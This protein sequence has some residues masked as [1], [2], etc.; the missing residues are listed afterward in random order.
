MAKYRLTQLQFD[1]I[2]QVRAAKHLRASAA[3]A[4]AAAK[5]VAKHIAQDVVEGIGPALTGTA[6]VGRFEA[7]VAVLIIDRALACIAEHLGGLLGFLEFV[8]GLVIAGIAIRM[9]LHRQAAIGLFDI[10]FGGRLRDIQ[11][12]VVIALRHSRPAEPL[13]TSKPPCPDPPLLAVEA[14]ARRHWFPPAYEARRSLSLTSSN[15]ASTTS[16]LGPAVPP[17]AAPAPAAPPAC[18][19]APP[20]P[21]CSWA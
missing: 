10:C 21:P 3:A 9:E 17:P 6:L 4:S 16:S 20:A 5:D 15:S 14:R 1:L 8:L 12:F 11:N 19:P 13:N 7:R 2:A 18:A